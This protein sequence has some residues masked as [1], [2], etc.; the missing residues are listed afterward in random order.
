M[1]FIK[2][3]KNN[4]YYKRFQVKFRRRRE[5]KTDYQ[6]RKALITQDKNKYNSPKYRLVVRF[7]NKDVTCQV[8]YATLTC[9]IIL[10][11]AYSHELSKYGAT[12]YQK[13]GQKNYA[14]AYATGLLCARRV[15]T[16]LG[17]DKQY[18]GQTKPD[19]ADYLVEA[20]GEGRRPFYVLLD[21]GLHFTT[22]G[23]RVFGAMKG[24]VDGGL[25]IPHKNK[26]FPGYNAQ[27]K[28]FD[29]AVLRKHIFGGHVADYMKHLQAEDPEKYKKQFA[30][31]IKAGK[32]P[33]DLEKMW[34]TVHTNIRADPTYTKVVRKA[35][36]KKV[37]HHRVKLNDAA[38]KN[39][40]AQKIASSQKMTQ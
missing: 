11:A 19:G 31:Y 4:T 30:R 14:A 20:E 5:C 32:G 15:L 16:K 21:I 6:A 27:A 8:A 10:T 35:A 38:R 23:A 29:P 34:A 36:P 39:R 18:L 28:K 2:V 17:L 37:K 24:A 7:S 12:L 3:V 1:P 22:T 40:I 9:D 13:T 26:R 33:D 25:D